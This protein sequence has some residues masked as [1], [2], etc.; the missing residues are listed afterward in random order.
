MDEKGARYQNMSS[1]LFAAVEVGI[2]TTIFAV[3]GAWPAPDVNEGDYLAKARHSFDPEW[4][5]NDF[6]LNSGSVVCTDIYNGDIL[7]STILFN[8]F[9][10]IFVSVM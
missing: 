7:C 1:L 6:F 5:G 4:C 3:A 2:F 9:F 10:P 8:S